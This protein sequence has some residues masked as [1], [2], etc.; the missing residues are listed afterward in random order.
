MRGARCSVYMGTNRSCRYGYCVGERWTIGCLPSPSDIDKIVV[1]AETAVGG[2]YCQLGE[3][4]A[5]SAVELTG[6]V[7][8]PFGAPQARLLLAVDV[9]AASG[10]AKL[11]KLAVEG[12]PV[13]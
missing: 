13:G 12:L 1:R 5:G 2:E 9:P 6:T 7:V 3:I 8:T 10:G 4:A 11:V